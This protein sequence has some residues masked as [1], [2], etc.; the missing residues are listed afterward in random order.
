MEGMIIIEGS[1]NQIRISFP[2]SDI[3]AVKTWLAWNNWKFEMG[4]LV[5]IHIESDEIINKEIIILR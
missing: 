4:D 5:R 2:F 1:V 3:E